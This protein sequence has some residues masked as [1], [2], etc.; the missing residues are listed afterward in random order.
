MVKCS[1]R[2]SEINHPPPPHLKSQKDTGGQQFWHPR[3]YRMLQRT[4]FHGNQRNDCISLHH[5]VTSW[6]NG[7]R[8][9]AR[10]NLCVV[11]K[12]KS[13]QMH[14]IQGKKRDCK[15]RFSLTTIILRPFFRTLSFQVISGFE[16]Y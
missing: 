6:F 7:K 3:W 8:Q 11:Q 16:H 10:I 5:Q 12:K 15:K 4:C 9:L 1:P 2:C 13:P 14:L